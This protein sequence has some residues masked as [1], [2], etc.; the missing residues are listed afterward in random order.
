[1]QPWEG[2]PSSALGNQGSLFSDPCLGFLQSCRL[3]LVL[4]L[5][6][7]IPAT[8]R[9]NTS[10]GRSWRSSWLPLAAPGPGVSE[11]ILLICR[12]AK[13][14]ASPSNPSHGLCGF[15]GGGKESVG[16]SFS[17]QQKNGSSCLLFGRQE[18]VSIGT[19]KS[20]HFLLGGGGNPG[21]C[22]VEVDYVILGTSRHIPG[23]IENWQHL[24]GKV[25]FWSFFG[26]GGSD[27]K[28]LKASFICYLI[29][30]ALLSHLEGS[31][32]CFNPFIK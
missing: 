18:S 32:W 2:D 1:M 8:R 17:Q 13:R 23:G 29:T 6:L 16:L 21:G 26:G 22:E 27:N 9:K 4:K 3:R 12:Q 7:N 20:A 11:E 25:G 24:T 5:V 14:S 19:R 15:H 31:R 30:V 10:L 28:F